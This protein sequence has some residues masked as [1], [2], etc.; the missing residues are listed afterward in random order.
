M[1]KKGELEVASG[2][3]ENISEK[4][5]KKDRAQ[6]SNPVATGF[7]LAEE[8][9]YINLFKGFDVPSPYGWGCVSYS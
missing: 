9:S 5:E 4:E 3:V 8:E 2:D 6:D 1:T 7:T